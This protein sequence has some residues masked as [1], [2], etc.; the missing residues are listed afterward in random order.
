MLQNRKADEFSAAF[1]NAIPKQSLFVMSYL[2][3]SLT[4]DQLTLLDALW[5]RLCETGTSFPKR[6]L[7]RVLGTQPFTDV[8][9]GMA[10]GL[11][12]EQFESGERGYALTL[13][14]ALSTSKGKV[15]TD[16]FIRLLDLVKSLHQEDCELRQIDS[17]LICA[18]LGLSA[19]ESRELAGITRIVNLPT[20][21]IYFG[22]QSADRSKWF[23]AITE[24]VIELC[25]SP[26]SVTFFE[27][28][29][30]MATRP[31][32]LCDV[33]SSLFPAQSFGLGLSW[34]AVVG[35]SSSEDSKFVTA[36]RLDSLRR[37]EHPN[38]DCTRLICLCEELNACAAGRHAHAVIFLTRA[39][40]DHIPPVFNLK[41]F[42]EVAANYGGGGRSFKACVERLEQHVR[43]VADRL[44]H[45]SMRK[46]EMAPELKEVA[47]SQ[48]LE[49]VLAEV[50]RI[51]KP[52]KF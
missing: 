23:L 50:C 35:V 44:L 19:S 14:G 28:K 11:F 41:S 26:S 2:P 51:L 36:A 7:L 30:A 43:K 13:L 22:G 52:S 4:A 38:F 15:L 46:S 49:T 48:E 9:A 8:V 21:P 17:D 42:A 29:L 18:K 24:D 39:I 16:L 45:Q 34:E 32:E 3:N 40:L 12:F 10:P 27:N 6:S 47:F 31:P 37:I 5:E 25:H 33:S 1:I 20:M